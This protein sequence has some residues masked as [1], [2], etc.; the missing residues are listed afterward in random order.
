MG[1]KYHKDP[2]QSQQS[3]VKFETCTKLNPNMKPCG[4]VE[5]RK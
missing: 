3:D 1:W 4:E 5:M 2:A